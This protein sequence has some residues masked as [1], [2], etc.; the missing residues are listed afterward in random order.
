MRFGLLGPL[1]V[2]AAGTSVPVASGRQRALLAALLLQPGQVVSADTLVRHVWGDDPPANARAALQVHISRLRR[3]LD[4]HGPERVVHRPPGYLIALAP[5][6]ELDLAE[7]DAAIA[8]AD[9]AAST[10]DTAAE[11]AHLGRALA[12]WRGPALPDIEST[13]EVAQLLDERHLNAIERRVDAELSLGRHAEVVPELR[14]LTARHPLRERLWA[15]LMLA[16]AASGQQADAL[17][18]YDRARKRL[19]ADLGVEPGAELRAAHQRVLRPERDPAP[20]V[21]P[22]QLPAGSPAFTGRGTYLDRL[23]AARGATASTVGVCAIVGTAG[24]GKT[25]LAVHWGHTARRHFPDGQLY[26]NMRGFATTPPVPPAEALA[27][28]LRA[29]GVPPE[30][31]P[32]DVDEA[33][34]LFRSLLAGKRVL[35]VLDNVAGANQVRP[36]IPGSAGCFVLVTSRNHLSGLVARDGA[37]RLAL[38]TM[39][40]AEARALLVHTLGAARVDADPPAAAALAQACAHLPLALRIVAAKLADEP[41]RGIADLAAALRGPD[42]LAALELNGDSAVWSAF[43]LSEATL[44]PAA[45]R[46]FALLGLAPTADFTAAT[47]GALTGLTPAEGGRLLR[48]LAAAHLLDEVGPG[49]FA[50]HD[51]LRRYAVSRAEERYGEPER[52]AAVRRLIDWYVHTTDA[53]AQAMYPYRIRLHPPTPPESTFD[54]VSAAAG[55]LDDEADNLVLVARS[56]AG[57]AHRPASWLLADM[58]RGYYSVSGRRADWLSTG[59]A[60]LRAAIAEGDL[61]G[62]AAMHL[63]LGA[64]YMRDG[65]GEL[66]RTHFEE[67]LDLARRI[68]W[69]DGEGAALG[70]LGNAYRQ[71][72]R[73][74]QAERYLRDASE[75][76]EKMGQIPLLAGS[77]GNLGLALRELGRLSEAHDCHERALALYRK[78]GS[79]YGEAM[80][81]GNL[82]E[83]YH[84]LGDNEAALDHLVRALDLHRE[85]SDRTGEA[86]S[87]RILATVHRDAGRYDE[88]LADGRYALAFARETGVPQA[89]TVALETVASIHLATGDT[90]TAADLYEQALA[91][92]EDTGER[93]P[94]VQARLGLARARAALGEAASAG[95]LATEANRLATAYHYPLLA[96]EAQTLL[97]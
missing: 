12:L 39:P 10:R 38:D 20:A 58:L 41:R 1:L 37:D 26:V 13:S 19:V 4:G 74:D 60:G 75:H 71:L 17:S 55:W 42:G 6:D 87:R 59:E 65:A 91:L 14:A 30:R 66:A 8:A 16:L 77:L 54:D 76:F 95:E 47:A 24:V 73:T 25:A 7:F 23:D 5:G 61:R 69:S 93:Y 82:G 51:L 22:A 43:E 53:A 64:V 36:L 70:L 63:N 28:F 85:V 79:R 9:E 96:T 11:V 80:G 84:D 2:E 21:A 18:T 15:Q 32:S 40:P 27:V 52:A 31:I 86:E 56:A 44:A 83:I 62:Q 48:T 94:A 45:A 33:A 97:H 81:L 90:R 35:V 67:L 89:E 50:C 72:G 49:R 3:A 29:L 46:L 34:G 78:I 57:G 92:A 88:A 68:A